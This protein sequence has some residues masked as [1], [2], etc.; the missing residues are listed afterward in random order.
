[1]DPPIWSIID[2]TEEDLAKLP[3]GPRE[4]MLLNLPIG[5]LLKINHDPKTLAPLRQVLNNPYFW[6]K[7]MT[8]DGFILPAN[9][10][11]FAEK[12]K[13]INQTAAEFL[14]SFYFGYKNEKLHIVA[15]VDGINFY[16]KHFAKHAHRQ[17]MH[18]KMEELAELLKAEQE[19][20]LKLDYDLSALFFS[21][22]VFIDRYPRASI[23]TFKVPN[24]TKDFDFNHG[25]LSDF[26]D[27]LSQSNLSLTEYDYIPDPVGIITKAHKKRIIEID[28]VPKQDKDIKDKE[29][30]DFYN[31]P[32]SL[33]Q[34]VSTS[35]ARRLYVPD[36][37]DINQPGYEDVKLKIQQYLQLV[38]RLINEG[39]IIVSNHKRFYVYKIGD[40]LHIK[41]YGHILPE[42]AIPFL[43]KNDLSTF[44]QIHH[45][46]LCSYLEYLGR[47]IRL[48]DDKHKIIVINN[49][50]FCVDIEDDNTGIISAPVVDTRC[51]WLTKGEGK[52]PIRCFRIASTKRTNNYFCT[53]HDNDPNMTEQTLR[54]E[55]EDGATTNTT[56]E[57]I[58]LERFPMV[59][60]SNVV[61][62]RVIPTGKITTR[63]CLV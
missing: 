30:F 6:V 35:R 3:Q 34:T 8:A 26:I 5:K 53:A 10:V 59:T 2:V 54:C 16:I 15:I 39:D 33:D 37:I 9:A 7:R 51:R 21:T 40:L 55:T 44:T 19:Q 58:P 62:R 23:C 25:L 1:M 11:E 46:Y 60:E 45:N 28:A 48:S 63:R 43:I 38:G 12:W 18:R 4:L 32:K 29:K 14:F 27:Q 17:Q 41:S 22:K 13:K 42:Q 36:T 24:F 52:Y 61:E 50:K 31:E 47:E 56:E 57:I 49:H 20:L